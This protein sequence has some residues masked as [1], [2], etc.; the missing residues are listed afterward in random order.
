M[1]ERKMDDMVADVTLPAPIKLDVDHRVG[2]LRRLM[3][4]IKSIEAR[5]E[6]E[7]RRY[8]EAEQKLKGT[9]MDYLRDN[10]LKTANTEHNGKITWVD[11]TTF[12]IEDQREFQSYVIENQL[13]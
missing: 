1:K 12:P 4:V 5:H 6:E 3:A 10:G 11:K 7:L 13:W 2:Q 8:K 9:L